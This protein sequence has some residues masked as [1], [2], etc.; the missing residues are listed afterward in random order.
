MLSRRH[1]CLLRHSVPMFTRR[2][3]RSNVRCICVVGH[4]GRNSAQTMWPTVGG[5][6]PND[7]AGDATSVVVLGTVAMHAM[8]AGDAVVVIMHRRADCPHEPDAKGKPPLAAGYQCPFCKASAD[9]YSRECPHRFAAGSA[10][11]SANKAKTAFE[12]EV[13]AEA[14]KVAMELYSQ[15][16]DPDRCATPEPRTHR[17]GSPAWTPRE[18]ATPG[19]G[20]RCRQLRTLA[21]LAV[22]N[23]R[24]LLTELSYRPSRPWVLIGNGEQSGLHR[25]PGYI[26]NQEQSPKSCGLSDPNV[27]LAGSPAPRLVLPVLEVVALLVDFRVILGSA[28]SPIRLCPT[29][30]LRQNFVMVILVHRESVSD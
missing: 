2:S 21:A 13:A 6:R 5:S 14:T 20:L 16:E 23:G 22:A 9:H 1:C 28:G 8:R 27:P 30:P 4:M 3:R 11:A 12:K 17:R 29:P 25:S 19:C 7:L 26:V 24:C 10:N 15:Y 18:V